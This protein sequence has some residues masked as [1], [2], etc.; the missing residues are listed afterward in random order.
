MNKLW[1]W[2][3]FA[4]G[5]GGRP[6]AWDSTFTATNP[7]GLDDAVVVMDPA[8]NRALV[9]TSPS[10]LT[11]DVTP[12]PVGQGV[13]TVQA[14]P[15]GK[16]L[17][18][19]SR[20]VSPRR[21]P[22]DERPRL[23]LIDTDPNPRVAHTYEFDDAPTGLVL[24]PENHWAVLYVTSSESEPVSNPQLIQLIDL[25]NPDHDPIPI[26]VQSANGSPQSFAFTSELTVP[27]GAPR[28]LLVVK[29][30]NEVTLID[31]GKDLS[32]SQRATRQV[33]IQMPENQQG[34]KG[35]PGQVVLHDSVADSDPA[36]ALDAELAVSLLGDS[37]VLLVDL[38]PPADGSALP[39]RV[40]INLV[41]V[42]GQP[43]SIQF[44]H[45]DVGVQLAA[46]VGSRAAL[47]DPKTGNVL[48]VNLA[49]SFSGMA[50]VTDALSKTAAGTDIALLWGSTSPTIGLWSLG[51][52]TTSAT[53]GLRTL[54]VGASISSVIDVPGDSFPTSKILVGALGDFYV[55]DLAKQQS[56]PMATN[57]HQYQLTFAPDGQSTR[58]WA[59]APSGTGFSSLNLSTLVPTGLHAE[60]AIWSVFDIAQRGGGGGRTA[61]VLH[62]VGG[63]FGATVLDGIDPDD[64]STRFYS[65]L[66]YRGLT[67][68]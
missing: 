41:D 45:A 2:P 34:A 10:P 60:R 28:R 50:L 5:C 15:D 4:L 26:T 3:L 29:T 35:R 53:H 21:D 66:A 9:L 22:K 52:A 1:L 38:A 32:D 20:G 65:G 16:R 68:E 13:T 43:S 8:L 17:F 37:N 31:L 27:P 55:L 11:L 7:V 51:V 56:S 6:A 63:D 61:V 44:V 59:Y 46:L 62:D 24:D 67:H 14:S 19:L 23:T 39:F 49:Q 57:G 54:D 64:A 42:R 58:L 12:V 40:D 48:E 47:V 30:Q 18:V 25:D 33:T 36:R